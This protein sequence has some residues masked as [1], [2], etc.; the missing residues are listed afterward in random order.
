[1]FEKEY[2][3]V[4]EKEK[5]NIDNG[6]F[7]DIDIRELRNINICS[8]NLYNSVIYLVLI[9]IIIFF[10]WFVSSRPYIQEENLTVKTTPF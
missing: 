6:D 3:F 2:F 10:V 4:D 5:I 1:M 8:S 9:G 7:R